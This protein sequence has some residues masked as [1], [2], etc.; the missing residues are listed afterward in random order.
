MQRLGT[1]KIAVFLS[2]SAKL[3]SMAANAEDV[4]NVLAGPLEQELN[5]SSRLYQ[6]FELQRIARYKK[7]CEEVKQHGHSKV[8]VQLQDL[9][10]F[11]DEHMPSTTGRVEKAYQN[12]IISWATILGLLDK[13]N[14]SLTPK[15]YVLKALIKEDYSQVLEKYSPSANPFL[16]GDKE[17]ILFLYLV[18]EN[19]GGFLRRFLPK[20][21]DLNAAFD[22]TI[23]GGPARE[24]LT[25]ILDEASASA[26]EDPETLERL[27]RIARVKEGL[28]RQR[29]LEKTSG[30]RKPGQ[31]EH[32]VTWRLEPLV[33][34]GLLSKEK[35][36]LHKYNFS[37][38]GHRLCHELRNLSNIGEY[39]NNRFFESVNDIFDIGAS[40]TRSC[41]VIKGH[42]ARGYIDIKNPQWIALI[43]ETVLL[44]AIHA[45]FT[46]PQPAF[47]EVTQ[48]WEHVKRMQTEHPGRVRLTVDSRGQ[49]AYLEIERNFASELLTYVEG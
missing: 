41:E 46:V 24:T 15:G 30:K 32:Q 25:E 16:I 44:S 27:Q 47:F 3:M 34:L 21:E 6:L 45:L 38:S 39:L 36:H 2:S 40:P 49:F 20:L 19:D 29:E 8:S 37:E 48:G 31:R 17:K 33:D 13:D 23:A 28:D 42:L 26:S 14:Y 4:Y 10:I 22:R 43:E 35:V 18:L 12:E 11:N 1:L 5:H 7:A 9:Y